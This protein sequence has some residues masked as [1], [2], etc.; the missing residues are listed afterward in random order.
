[1][2]FPKFD[3]EIPFDCVMSL[4]SDIRSKTLS[5]FSLIQKAAWIA[6]CSAAYAANGI[7]QPVPNPN[8]TAEEPY[9]PAGKTLEELA[10]KIHGHLSAVS[11]GAGDA[12]APAKMPSWL[13]PTILQ[14]LQLILQNLQK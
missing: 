11:V 1:M 14:M 4:V 13:L 7:P 6:G 5:T 8:V 10:D 2:S 3:A 9:D 12:A